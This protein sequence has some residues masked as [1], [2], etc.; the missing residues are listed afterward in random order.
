MAQLAPVPTTSS[1]P[2]TPWLRR[3][4]LLQWLYVGRLTVVAA[5]LVA[6]LANW[7]TA[8]P[9]ET[10]IVSVMFISALGVTAW[11]FWYTHLTRREPGENFLY[12]QVVLDALIVTGIVHLTG[13]PVSGFASLYILVI[14]AGALLLPLPGG[15]LIGGLVS[16]LYFADLVWGYQETFTIFVALRIALFTVVALITGLLGDR[17]RRAGQAL[18]EVENK[19]Q[20]LRLDTGDILANL[21]TGV[22]TVD[23]DGR[24][25]YENPAAASLLDGRLEGFMGMPV[26]DELDRIAPPLGSILQK[27]IHG[28]TSVSRGVVESPSSRGMLRLGV[29]TA[30]LEREGGA[31]PSA[32][33]LF[34]DITD[35][36]R[37]DELNVRNER[38]E[39]VAT[40]SASLA[41]EIKNPLAS[42]RSA[43]EQLSG[44]RLSQGDRAVL[45]RLV[46]SESDRLSRLLTE[47]LDYS[48]LGMGATERVDLQALVRGCVLFAKQHPALHGVD[49]ET[50]VDDGPIYVDGDADLLHRALFNLV[51]NGGQSAGTG[52][53]VRVAL[54]DERHRRR[55]RGTDIAHPVR[56]SV[57]DSGPGIPAVARPRIFDPFFTTKDA[58]SGLGLAVV[59][60]AVEAHEGATFVEE[61]AHGGAE[62]VIFLPGAREPADAQTQ[63]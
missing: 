39:A 55:P 23:G 9:S 6:V 46:L 32:T 5:T 11:S 34:Q 40:L 17:L 3:R 36:E 56:L 20:Q 51:L 28:G 38:L 26:L 7:Y 31:L 62:F 63:V 24:L 43:V 18:G 49:I 54:R 21:S 19:L 8:R 53:R 57:G 29:S 41:H 1:G 2:D 14:S 30:V 58:G 48:G 27:A 37:L 44:Q 16:I 42:I 61:S 15:V 60:R 33:A 50:V 10:L 45:E 4:D 59:H 35:L 52:G 25:A 12:A 13:G 22:I 47:F